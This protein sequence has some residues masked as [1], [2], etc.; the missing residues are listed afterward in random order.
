MFAKSIW[1]YV[2][3]CWKL[4]MWNL[5]VLKWISS[6][7]YV[8]SH[9][10]FAPQPL[11]VFTL[12]EYSMKKSD[13]KHLTCP[14][15]NIK[16]LIATLQFDFETGRLLENIQHWISFMNQF[17]IIIW[18]SCTYCTCWYCNK[19]VFRYSQLSVCVFLYL[20]L[21]Q[22]IIMQYHLLVKGLFFSIAH[23]YVW[24]HFQ[25]IKV[26]FLYL[27]INTHFS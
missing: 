9:R 5:Q 7:A 11:F 10:T 17:F 22:I 4:M 1:S 19:H 27:S 20:L 23:D 15:R 26:Y 14:L 3:N 16:D 12:S 18:T 21:D 25:N 8:L 13:V 6:R 2:M 24:Q